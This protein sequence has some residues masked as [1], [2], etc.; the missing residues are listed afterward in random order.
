MDEQNAH[1][2]VYDG[3]EVS[4]AQT[5]FVD[6]I[7]YNNM[8]FISPIGDNCVLMKCIVSIQIDPNLK[9]VHNPP[10]LSKPQSHRSDS[11]AQAGCFAEQP[12]QRCCC[13]KQNSCITYDSIHDGHMNPI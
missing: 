3:K 1:Q 5:Q 10:S 12:Y 9:F 2:T 4:I 11:H 7:F 8:S 13:S 6:N